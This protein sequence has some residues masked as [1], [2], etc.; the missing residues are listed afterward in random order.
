MHQIA[1]DL[2]GQVRAHR[3]FVK[4]WQ[5]LPARDQ[6]AV[7]IAVLRLLEC[8]AYPSLHVH[9]IA[10]L[11]GAFECYVSRDLR[12]L[13]CREQDGGLYLLNVGCHRCIERAH[14]LRLP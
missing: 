7:R 6:Q 8:P 4:S 13:Y 9:S 12:L 11:P 2:P 5:R 3:L 1:I 14:L 10:R